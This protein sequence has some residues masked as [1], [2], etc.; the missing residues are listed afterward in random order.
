MHPYRIVDGVR[1]LWSDGHVVVAYRSGSIAVMDPDLSAVHWHRQLPAPSFLKAFAAHFRL[2]RRVLRAE[3]TDAVAGAPGEIL[4]NHRSTIWRLDLLK[5]TLIADFTIPDGRNCLALCA[6]SGLADFTDGACLGEYFDNRQKAAVNIWRRRAGDGSWEIAHRFA[7]GEIDHIHALVPDPHRGCVWILTGDFG[8][9]AAL[10]Q[11]RDDFRDVIPILRGDQ[12]Y[13]AAWLYPT[14]DALYYATDTQLEQNHLCRLTTA[15]EDG[16]WTVDRIRPLPGSSIYGAPAMD[17]M[18]FST[19]VEPGMPSGRLVKDMLERRPGPG[20]TST[21]AHVFRLEADGS[22]L[23]IIAAEKDMWPL[24]LM[25]FGTFHLCAS[26]SG[27][28]YAYGVA[29]CG[30]DGKAAILSPV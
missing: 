23:D 1:P 10:W 4:I 24:R 16:R 11:A 5:R 27:Q 28:A 6:L 13:R 30:W 22:C 14:A 12:L 18:L 17:G 20:I 2:A 3:P 8:E 19:T 29:V 9:G 26:P 15:P 21:A 7:P 25:Q